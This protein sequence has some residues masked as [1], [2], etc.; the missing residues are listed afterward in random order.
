MIRYDIKIPNDSHWESLWRDIQKDGPVKHP[1]DVDGYIRKYNAK[2]YLDPLY[3]HIGVIKG[4][5]FKTE[6]DLL[7]FKLKF[8]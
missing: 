3:Q 7:Y 4:I 5:E 6:E 8:N 2:T 1:F